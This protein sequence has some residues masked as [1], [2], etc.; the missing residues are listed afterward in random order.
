MVAGRCYSTDGTSIKTNPSFR[1]AAARRS[2]RV[3]TPSDEGRRSAAMNAAA[4]LQRVGGTQW[5]HA[6]ESNRRFSNGVAR[7][8]FV[9]AIRELLQAIEGLR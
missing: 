3:T 2:S 4:K 5:M 8:D 7:I 6:Q 9:P 1:A